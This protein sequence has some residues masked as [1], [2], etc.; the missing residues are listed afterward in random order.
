MAAAVSCAVAQLL[1]PAPP[2]G[3][4]SLPQPLLERVAQSGGPALLKLV[5]SQL[6]DVVGAL[7]AAA[8]GRR[9]RLDVRHVAAR[10]V[11]LVWAVCELRCPLTAD[12]AAAVA[13][14]GCVAAL[15]W[16]RDQGCPWSSST[17]RAA[18]ASGH[19][20]LL[21]WARGQGCPW[22]WRVYLAAASGG[23]L[24]VMEWAW[25]QGLVWHSSVAGA[26][27][28]AGHRHALRWIET[29]RLPLELGACAEAATLAQHAGVLQWIKAQRNLPALC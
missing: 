14:S 11:T 16:A 6:R 12:T 13:S 9:S 28:R 25:C 3:L 1:L 15:Q 8:G 7:E 26:A 27:A 22:D 5:C 4:L 21:R 19:L 10:Q 20:H 2:V 24:P 18:A 17:C 23:H 29:K